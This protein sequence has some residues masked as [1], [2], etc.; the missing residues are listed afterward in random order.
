MSEMTDFMK[1][2]SKQVASGN[3]GEVVMADGSDITFDECE[4]GEM[5]RNNFGSS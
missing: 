3:V 4:S 2:L 5:Q 1:E